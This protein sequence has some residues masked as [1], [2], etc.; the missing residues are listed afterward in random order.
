MVSKKYN[1]SIRKKLV[2]FF[3]LSAVIALFISTSTTLVYSFLNDKESLIK[4]SIKLAEVS[5]KNIAASLLFLDKESCKNILKPILSD[6]NVQYVKIYNQDG[7]FFTSLG[8]NIGKKKSLQQDINRM[9]KSVLFSIDWNN[10]NIL[11]TI[12]HSDE[13]IGYLEVHLTTENLKKHVLDQA[14]ASFIIMLITTLIVLLL[15]IKLEKVFLKPIFELL[16]AMK[17][18]QKDKD[19]SISLV[20][21]AKDEFG[22]LFNEFNMMASEIYKRDQILHKHNL[23]LEIQVNTTT[24]KLKTTEDSLNKVSILATTD[25]LTSLFNRRHIMDIFD[26]MI[27]E[28]EN[29]KEYIGV[30]MLDID[31]FKLVNDTLGHQAGDVVLKE[32]SHILQENARDVD[33]VGRIGGEEFL[34]LCKNSDIKAVSFV[35]ERLRKKVQER[36]IHYEDDKTTQ[37][38]VSL[39]IYSCVPD[40]SKEELIKIADNA[41]Y[42]AK[43]TGRNRVSIGVKN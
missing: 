33:A 9:E 29:E 15:A 18:I 7:V 30:I 16:H 20:P 21:S 5:G 41:L 11:T 23:D 28:A 26:T 4:D 24:E 35:A 34:I 40:I 25:S 1:A 8:E 13:V 32:V 38:T 10:I 6:E 27:L 37:V 12:L 39:G 14:I 36:V 2:Y 42:D 17:Q 43:E 3:S 19:F 22:E 31:H